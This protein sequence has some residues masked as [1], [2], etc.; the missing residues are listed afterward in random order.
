[1]VKRRTETTPLDEQWRELRV[2]LAM[3]GAT[4]NELGAMRAAFFCG[5]HACIA[6]L[7]TGRGAADAVM[8]ELKR[9]MAT[10][11]ATVSRMGMH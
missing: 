7:A 2:H 1:V 4:E 3:G 5:A 6:V 8:A 9:D 10:S 11:Q